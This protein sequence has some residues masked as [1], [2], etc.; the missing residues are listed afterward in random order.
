M[1]KTEQVTIVPVK[2]PTPD[3][4]ECYFLSDEF[5]P[6]PVIKLGTCVHC[7]KCGKP[8]IVNA[9][10]VTSFG[11]VHSQVPVREDLYNADEL[12]HCEALGMAVC[13]TCYVSEED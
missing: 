5:S 9:C 8:C 10:T 7:E 1:K 6:T 12:G 3:G 11:R 4:I 13:S 2:A